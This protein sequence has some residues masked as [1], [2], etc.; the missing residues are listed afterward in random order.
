[1]SGLGFLPTQTGSASVVPAHVA[2]GQL[3]LRLLASLAGP[4]GVW[5]R[6]QLE[7]LA[8]PRSSSWLPWRGRDAGAAPLVATFATQIAGQDLSADVPVD[9]LGQVDASFSVALPPARRGWR[10]ARNHV[11]L[12]GRR[13]DMCSVL[14][15][16]ATDAH[17]VS[18]VLLPRSETLSRTGGQPFTAECPAG[19][20]LAH[21]APLVQAR[22]RRHFLCYVAWAP[23]GG[24]LCP[25][26]LALA[27]NA[28][29]WPHGHVL[30]VPAA[31][32]GVDAALGNLVERVRWLFA[33][34]HDVHILN[35]DPAASA[36]LHLLAP[37]PERANVEVV[38]LTADDTAAV[39]ASAHLRPTRSGLVT[40][41]PIV[42]CHGMLACTMLRG[43][44][45]ADY[46]YFR[47]LEKFFHERGFRV[48]FP[49]VAPTG[50]V[51]E[52]AVMLRELIRR[53]TSEPVNIVAHSMGGLDARYL[54]THL[55]MASQ[56]K[57]LTTIST[58]H[59]GTYMADWFR[60]NFR[61]RV[62]LLVAL[63][64]LGVSVDGFHD[65]RPSI[66][67]TF[68]ART[69]DLPGVRYFSYSGDVP[70]ARVTPMLRRAWELLAAAEGPNDGLVSVQSARWG[71]FL[72]TIPAD[73][74]A[75]TPDGLFV[76]PTESFD[77]LR[78][79]TRIVED[80][81]R[82]GF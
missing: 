31:A 56:V 35:F 64:A 26:E 67:R 54:I 47:P 43:Q 10:I 39:A 37:A 57:T 33:G 50:G 15:G 32:D 8:T 14:A 21:L 1:M 68:N 63:E 53:W 51:V 78:F 34:A 29:G 20:A 12:Q 19:S 18:L 76:H 38:D 41:Y 48:L 30:L 55:H 80:L 9:A 13:A 62:P 24:D 46:N 77:S 82:R 65:C 70:L 22:T 23:P 49:R 69:P 71:E 73:H 81:A 17:G 40:R 7:G 44:L 75:Q 79:F 59:H 6:G 58:P 61:H 45:T 25:A 5:L 60:D 28:L 4:R 72:G 36:S 66:C 2:A 3:K 11:T 52:R 27:L 42:F 74:F 16:P